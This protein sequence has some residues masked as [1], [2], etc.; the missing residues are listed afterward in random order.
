MGVFKIQVQTQDNNNNTGFSYTGIQKVSE[1]E[2]VYE[3]LY[4]AATTHK[5]APYAR[6]RKDKNRF[7]S[8]GNSSKLPDKHDKSKTARVEDATYKITNKKA[9]YRVTEDYSKEV[10]QYIKGKRLKLNTIDEIIKMLDYY[11]DLKD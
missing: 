5:I 2:D 10:K 7:I 9:F 8:N 6:L 11:S 4:L 3:V 1:V